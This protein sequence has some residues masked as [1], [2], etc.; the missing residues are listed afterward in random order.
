[1]AFIGFSI[2]GAAPFTFGFAQLVINPGV[3]FF[4]AFAQAYR[5]G[6][7]DFTPDL[8]VI[9]IAATHALRSVQLVAAFQLYAGDVFQN[10]N[11]LVDGHQLVAAQIQRFTAFA[12]Q[13][14][15]RAFHAI[16]DI[17]E[18]AGLFAVAPDID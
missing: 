8:G 2:E 11:H 3:G 17:H 14:A 16:V 6:P 18:A 5:R 9:G 10:G 1:M 12:L 7:A 15:E 4:Q 13:D